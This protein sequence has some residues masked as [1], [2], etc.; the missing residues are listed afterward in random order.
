MFTVKII[1]KKDDEVIYL[2]NFKS[3]EEK[4][5]KYFNLLK[6]DA[7]AHRND[8]YD[9]DEELKYSD[10]KYIYSKDDEEISYFTIGE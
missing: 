4:A 3:L 9:I 8:Y 2:R 6:Q 1:N 5:E 10:L 7:V